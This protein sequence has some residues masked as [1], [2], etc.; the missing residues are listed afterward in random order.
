MENNV[1]FNLTVCLMGVLI[2]TIHV[3]NMMVKKDKRKDEIVLLDFFVFTTVHFLIYLAYTFIKMRYTN[4]AFIILCY[5]LFYIMNNVAVFLLYRYARE[6]IGWEPKKRQVL[7]ILNASLFTVF[8]LLDLIN[9]TTGIFFTA[10][11]GVYL[12]SKTMIISQGYQFVMFAAVFLVAVTDKKLNLR[13]KTAFGLYCALPFGAIILQNIFKGYAIAYLSII[14]AIEVLFF[15][16]NVQKNI[17]L[18][19]EEEA[20]KDAKIKLMISQIRPHFVYNSLSAISTL[21]PIDPPKAQAALDDFSEYLRMNLS[22]LTEVRCISFENELKHIETYVALEKMRFNDRIRVVYDI[23]ARDFA[24]PLLTIQPIVENAIKHGILKRL[25]GGTL[26]IKTWETGNSFV[27][28]IS[29]DGVGFRIDDINF[30]EN[31]HFGLKNIEYRLAKMCHA[32]LL[33]DSKIGEGTTVKVIFPK[34]GIQ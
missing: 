32:D 18:A 8:F 30:D 31:K 1:V 5:T 21:I 6:Y 28:E 25:E 12:R 4:D 10:E 2:L 3:V 23:K 29:D 9:T 16:L 17:D 13:E 33:I 34:E 27:V 19:K 15:F 7:D 26:T 20:N 22:S 11:N 24:V 14:I